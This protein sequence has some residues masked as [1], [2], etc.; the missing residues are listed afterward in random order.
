MTRKV[1]SQTVVEQAAIAGA[2]IPTLLDD[3][4]RAQAAAEATIARLNAM[5]AGA[6]GLTGGWTSDVT[7]DAVY[8]FRTRRGVTHR[9]VLD[10][11]LLNS[12]EVR[13]LATMVEEFGKT[14]GEAATLR[15]K[16]KDLRRITGPLP[17]LEAVLEQGRHGV[18]IQR[19]KGL[20]EMNPD[21]L[22][23]TTLDPTNR[24][25]L[26]VRVNHADEAEEVFS[27]LMG[28]VV[29]PRREFIQDNALK[30]AN[31]DV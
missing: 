30:V 19:Y 11:D 5:P 8:L 4:A 31:L 1:G 28:D 26:Q 25:L 23:E 10:R 24:S 27:T 22:W 16:E 6:D 2:L 9:Y 15:Q 17:L 13:R 3:E 14:Y 29:E 18:A 21:Q 7:P 12:A 20:G